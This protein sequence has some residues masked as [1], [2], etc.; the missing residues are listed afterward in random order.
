MGDS[1]GGHYRDTGNGPKPIGH[2]VGNA[3]E[4]AAQTAYRAYLNHR[5]DCPQCQ[6]TTFICDAATALWETYM[7]ARKSA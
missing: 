7:D 2:L 1:T 6:Q 5:P 3:L 4:G